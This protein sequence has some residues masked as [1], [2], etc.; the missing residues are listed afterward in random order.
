MSTLF[1]NLLF[2]SERF[3]HCCTHY[4]LMLFIKKK[5]YIAAII[6]CIILIFFIIYNF[7]I[8]S[9]YKDEANTLSKEYFQKGYNIDSDC[10]K[11]LACDE[12]VCISDTR[13]NLLILDGIYEGCEIDPTLYDPPN[14]GP[15]DSHGRQHRIRALIR[16]LHRSA[17]RRRRGRSAPSATGPRAAAVPPS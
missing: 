9:N 13:H 2:F 15:D 4:I 16:R 7:S 3:I 12:M 14:A 6:L 11:M 8:L 1:K 17:A 10:K 5:L